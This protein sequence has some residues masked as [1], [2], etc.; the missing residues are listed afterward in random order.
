MPRR[1]RLATRPPG[2]T[3]GPLALAAALLSAVPA[4]GSAWSPP[5]HGSTAV[6]LPIADGELTVSLRPDGDR[7]LRLVRDDTHRWVFAGDTGELVGEPYTI[8]LRN[9]T[10]ERLKVV[11]GVDGL[12]VYEREVVSGNARD[13][14][15]S[16]LAPWSERVLPG[17]Q[18][19]DHRAQR[20]V[21]SPNEWS[22]GQGR[23]EA[24][25][26]RVVVQ[27]YREWREPVWRHRDRDDGWKDG[28]G[29]R[30]QGGEAA[31]PSATRPEPEAAEDSASAPSARAARPREPIGTTAG[32]DVASSVRTVR[33]AAATL[34]PETWAVI[35]YGGAGDPHRPPGWPDDDDLLG[36]DLAPGRDGARIVAVAPGSAAER[37]GL[38]PY[39]VIVR[40]DSVYAP[41]PSDARRLL[42]AKDRGDYA[43]LR[44]RRGAHELAVKI[45]V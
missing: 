36:L 27:A 16:I 6:S 44:V 25:I 12:N 18:I 23:T 41:S 10:S 31:P 24:Q 3:L 9:D 26:G 15:G 42:R 22:E 34:H 21:F 14:V 4:A 8:V 17:W 30:V 11:V 40:L 28:S 29:P 7:A 37:A 39:D 13:D 33:F 19:G 1:R 32:D 38:E 45:R 43:F 2:A 20:F 5:W 35:D